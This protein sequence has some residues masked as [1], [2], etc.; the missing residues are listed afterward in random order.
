MI[1]RTISCLL[2]LFLSANICAQNK[3]NATG[4]REGKWIFTGKELPQTGVSKD[5]KVEEGYYINGRKHGQWIKY[6][7]DGKTPKLKGNYTDNRPEGPYTRYH[8]NGKISEQGTFG[9]NGYKGLLIRY[10]ENGQI[11]YKANYNNEGQEIG[12]VQ[13]YHSNGRI[14]LSYTVKA[15]SVRGKV[16]RYDQ[17]G[18]L[19]NSFEIDE[20]GKISAVQK[21]TPKQAQVVPHVAPSAH[22][23]IYPPHLTNPKMKGLRFEPNGYNK[24]FN[25]ND[26]IWMDG[27]FKNGQL[28][29]GKVYDYDQDGIL[30]KVRIFKN[31]RYHSEGQL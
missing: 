29:D 26:E 6:Y 2:C 16:S 1:L 31:G 27:E 21:A 17:N 24:V 9:K 23:S 12:L 7:T 10:Y 20:I 15:G 19:I 18:L 28:F 8:S 30:Q 5:T 22:Q 13:Y 25:G 3:R 4:K 11:A 14:S